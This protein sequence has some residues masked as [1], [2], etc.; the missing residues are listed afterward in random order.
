MTR[1]PDPPEW[2][3]TLRVTLEDGD[4]VEWDVVVQ[5]QRISLVGSKDVLLKS[6]MDGHWWFWDISDNG[7]VKGDGYNPKL[8]NHR[9][10]SE[11][12]EQ[13]YQAYLA[14]I[15]VGQTDD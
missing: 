15:V 10:I 11:A 5:G 9:A 8:F 4:T 3:T 14:A 1:H 2:R 12:A 6:R 13:V 7:T